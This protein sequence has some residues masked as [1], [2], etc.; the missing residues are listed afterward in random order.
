MQYL[1]FPLLLLIYFEVL[2]RVI[3]TSLKRKPFDFSFVVGFIFVM[4]VLYVTCWP[5]TA[6][7]GNFYTLLVLMIIEFL[8]SLVLIVKQ[9]KNIDWS[10]DWK[11]GLAFIVVVLFECYISYNRTL[12][13][14]HGFDTL[15]Y[16]NFV[17][18]NIGNPELNSVHP[19]FGTVPN[20][21]IQQITYV[22][23]SMYYFASVII[24]SGRKVL[25]IIGKTFETLPAYFWTFQVM[26]HAM[27]VGT[28]LTCLKEIKS[29]NKTFNIAMALLLLLFVGNFYYNNVFGFIG[30]NWRMSIHAIA[31]LFLFRYFKNNE[32]ID[33]YIFYI[34]QLALCG[35]ASTGTF[36]A[37]FVLFGLFYTFYRT[38]KNVL[39]E[40]ALV[41][42]VPAYN[43]IVTKLG[44]DMKWLIA[45][46]VLF[47][48]IYLL[49]DFII[50]LFKNKF[51]RYGSVI[52]LFLITFIASLLI[53]K[54]PFNFYAFTNNYSE[55]ADMSWDYFDFKDFR[56]WIFN[57]IVL[58]PS[59]YYL[60]KNKEH[61]FS[62]MSLLLIL[63]IY[64][65][66]CCTFINKIN[67][68]YYRTYD[69]IINQYT[70]ILFS[71]YLIEDLKKENLKK[72]LS[73]VLLACSIVLSVIQ[74][75]RVY[76]ETFIPDENYNKLL[77]IDNRELELIQNVR[78]LI[79]VHG[80]KNPRIINQTFLMP[81]FIQDAR[82]LFGKEKRFNLL[83]E[84]NSRFQ[85]YHIF[86]PH[87]DVYD[88]YYFEADIDYANT[89]FYLEDSGYDILIID[90]NSY[91]QDENGEY[92]PVTSLVDTDKFLE[93]YGTAD[94]GVYYLK[95]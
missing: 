15:Y 33:L 25:G 59:T 61:P 3:L 83:E 48:A 41:L 73:L 21:E 53:T 70:L 74:I 19:H 63:I 13:E 69:I 27:L 82:N 62:K 55:Y 18:Y 17:N 24:F 64:N 47:I 35:V 91:Y 93:E 89:N 54:N 80:I 52:V 90:R 44:T 45:T 68:V 65:P 11:L 31:T 50:T 75:P 81:S 12:G 78:E 34:C 88:N 71:V 77:K 57:P 36:A 2:G 9:F 43:V 6:F 40:Y 49:N 8:G 56:H 58:I 5:I 30:N 26:L 23:Q 38:R 7:N 1:L 94:Y 28:S 22:F 79:K 51:V 10:F 20:N 42:F 87:D 67:W 29:K 76:H 32:D 37:V 92:K 46:I 84:T 39:K 95:P 60:V 66:F 72:S 85:C 14:L 86:F 4:A 16:L